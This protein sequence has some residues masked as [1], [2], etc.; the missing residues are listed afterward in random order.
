M[1]AA[2][3]DSSGGRARRRPRLTRWLPAPALAAVLAL[4]A[5]IV[6]AVVLAVAT[7]PVSSWLGLP[8]GAI[9]T[10]ASDPGFDSLDLALWAAAV[11]WLLGAAG[12][13]LVVARARERSRRA[14][15]IAGGVLALAGLGSTLVGSAAA[16]WY[17]PLVF[18][19]GPAIAMGVAASVRESR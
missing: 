19:A 11:G 7:V 17:Y 9:L 14:V 5:A 2:G 16:D 13:G 12:A 8:A 1:A 6:V 18:F 3:S 10:D 4:L 15:L